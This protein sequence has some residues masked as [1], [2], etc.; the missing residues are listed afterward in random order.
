MAAIGRRGNTKIAV[1]WEAS[2]DRDR[3]GDPIFSSP[4]EV[5]CRWEHVHYEMTDPSGDK[6]VVDARVSLNEPVRDD[7][8][9][10]L[11]TLLK[12]YGVGS[13]SVNDQNLMQVIQSVR[14]DDTRGRDT[15][16]E[17]LLRYYRKKP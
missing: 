4:R 12:W 7:S 16:Y 1:Y 6:V 15:R 10:Y 14:A 3:Q 8:L 17:A 9:L 5:S 13:G 2:G 11:G